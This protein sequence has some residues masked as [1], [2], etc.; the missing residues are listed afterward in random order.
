MKFLFITVLIISSLT[1]SAAVDVENS[2]SQAF[3]I[4][5]YVDARFVQFGEYNAVPSRGFSI[6]RAGIE[7]EADITANFKADVKIE[8]SPDNIFLKDALVEWNPFD[9]ARGRFGQFRRA[10]LLGGELSTWNLPLMDRPLVYDLREDLAYCGRDLGADLEIAL[11]VFHGVQMTGTAGV[12]NGDK[13]GDERTDSELLYSFRGVADILPAG[14]SLGCSAISHRLGEANSLE[15]DGYTS[16]A[17]LF[18]F[19]GDISIEHDFSNWYGA[20]LMAEYSTG[21]NWEYSD[22]LAGEDPPSFSGLWGSLT[23]SYHPWNVHAIRTV[24]L[25]IGYDE[26]KENTDLDMLHRKTSVIGAVYPTENLR[27]RFGGIRNTIDGLF[28]DDEYTDLLLEASVR[29]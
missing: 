17:R 5:G 22:V 19:S 13:R 1:A 9:F 24:S 6:R 25:T 16:S 28:A 20:S 8:M 21:D 26:L 27:L 29:V 23:A 18:A 15:P 10:T 4:N 7:T 12:F 11:P 2:L 3:S 14:V